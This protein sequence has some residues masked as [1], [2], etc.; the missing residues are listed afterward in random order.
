MCDFQSNFSGKVSEKTATAK[1]I[2]DTSQACIDAC[3]EEKQ[4]GGKTNFVTY[5]ESTK[6]CHCT[7]GELS[8][9]NKN[10]TD[11]CFLVPK[12]PGIDSKC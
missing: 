6:K 11:A 4:K 5:E 2:K 7:A 3:V 10:G 9:K 12:L 1:G 8:F